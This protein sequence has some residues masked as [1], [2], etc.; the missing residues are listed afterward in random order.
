MPTMLLAIACSW[1]NQRNTLARYSA[2]I[3]LSVLAIYFMLSAPLMAADL[4]CP[5]D[6][7]ISVDFDNGAGWDLCWQSKQRE[8]IVLSEIH[9]S[10]PGQSPGQVISTLRL[11]QLHVAYDDSNIT[12]N[13]VTQFGLGAGFVISL[14]DADCPG[15]ELIDIDG[16]PGLCKLMLRGDDAYRTANET[17]LAENLTLFSISQVGSYT[18]LVTWKFF[19]DGSIAPSIGAA[20]ALQRSSDMPQSPYGRELEGVPDKSWLSHT[21]NYYWRIDFDIGENAT[22]DVVSEVSF[23]P[24]SE[25]RRARKVVPLLQESAR[26]IDTDNMLAWSITS[27]NGDIDQAPGYLIE[28]LHHGHKLVRSVMEPYTD[29]DFF[30]TR[31][32]DCERFV[33]ENAKFN[34]DCG[35]NILQFVNDESLVDQDIVVWH[36]ISFHHVPRNEDR[37]HMHSHWDGF[38]MQARNLSLATPGH[39]G[40]VDNSPPVV[41]TLADLDNSVAEKIE[42][43]ITASDPDNDTLRFTAIG[44]PDGI[45]LDNQGRFSGAASN[46]GAYAV[47]VSVSDA[48]H[49]VDIN[50]NWQINGR[51]GSGAAWYL[52][53]IVAL[54]LLQRKNILRLR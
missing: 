48:S 16:R 33:S 7:Q 38:V 6:H 15:G 43:Q 20:G 19:D 17:R 45:T 42:I 23:P 37:Q 34:P 22:D 47:T 10:S 46:V 13:D 5:A 32:S 44:L 54:V 14:D 21:H 1:P 30:V 11:S 35:E 52:M 39:S 53:W 36:R 26:K 28:P 29:Y 8:N 49:T 50:F 51:S 3:A 25:G 31:Q 9:F 40:R 2:S 24:D 18:Y 27:G 4:T 12:Y 41:A